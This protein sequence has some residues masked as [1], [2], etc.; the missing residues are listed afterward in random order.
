[1][2]LFVYFLIAIFFFGFLTVV[3][4][5]EMSLLNAMVVAGMALLWPATIVLLVIK[6]KDIRGE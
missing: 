3:T 1:M 4:W 2:A 5:S 6:L